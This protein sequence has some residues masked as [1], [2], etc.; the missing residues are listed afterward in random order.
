VG[1]RQVVGVGV[2]LCLPLVATL[3]G[4]WNTCLLRPI[5]LEDGRTIR[6]LADAHDVILDLPE[7]EL[8]RPKWQALVGLLLSAATTRQHHLLSILTVRLETE[9]PR[10]AQTAE[11]A[12]P[13]K[14]PPA[15]RV[16]HRRAKV[17]KV[18]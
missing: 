6:T 11:S 7:K 10:L 4:M 9:L 17:R 13:P 16:K 2:A 18:K 1:I 5:R 3:P 15:P 8:R 12:L 14:K